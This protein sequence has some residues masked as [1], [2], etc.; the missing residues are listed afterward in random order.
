MQL[1]LILKIKKNNVK[2][3]NVIN[4]INKDYKLINSMKNL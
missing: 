1:S 4:K 3:Q 2:L